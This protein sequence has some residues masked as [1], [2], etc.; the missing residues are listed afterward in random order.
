[1]LVQKKLTNNINIY[2]SNTNQN[3]ITTSLTTKEIVNVQQTRRLSVPSK[4][5][6]EKTN[7]NQENAKQTLKNDNYELIGQDKLA[8]FSHKAKSTHKDAFVKSSS[9]STAPSKQDSS[10]VWSTLAVSCL[11]DILKL[12]KTNNLFENIKISSSNIQYN[13]T[14]VNKHGVVTNTNKS[15]DLPAWV[16]QAMTSLVHWSD[17]KKDQQ[18]KLN[19]H[20][21]FKDV[22]NEVTNYYN[23]HNEP[24]LTQ[25]FS[26]LLLKIMRI[27]LSNTKQ[28]EIDEFMRNLKAHLN[29][30]A[31]LKQ[32]NNDI[33]MIVDYVDDDEAE[34][35]DGIV[36]NGDD[37]EDDDYGDDD[38]FCEQ[39][40]DHNCQQFNFASSSSQATH[41]QRSK[42]LNTETLAANNHE[43][44]CSQC[45]STYDFVNNWLNCNE[46]E[47]NDFVLNLNT[48]YR[49]LNHDNEPFSAEEEENMPNSINATAATASATITDSE[50]MTNNNKTVKNEQISASENERKLRRN[51]SFIAAI[52]D[53]TASS[54]NS[55]SGCNFKDVTSTHL[56][57]FKT[58]SLDHI[59]EAKNLVKNIAKMTN[60][61][62]VTMSTTTAP[63]NTINTT[64]T[65]SA[66]AADNANTHACI[67]QAAH[68]RTPSYNDNQKIIKNMLVNSIS[69]NN[70]ASQ[71]PTQ[72][73]KLSVGQLSSLISSVSLKDLQS[74]NDDESNNYGFDDETFKQIIKAFR[75]FTLFLPPLNKRKLHLLLRLL[76]KLK[77]SDHA[78]LLLI[79][80]YVDQNEINEAINGA[81]QS[82][83]E[84]IVR[85]YLA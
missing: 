14:H 47:F 72:L 9:T 57:M 58:L 31:C 11:Y 17:F 83:V 18:N 50:Y 6:K 16:M 51:N 38:V 4:I 10:E 15:D 8:T 26:T 42:S 27:F 24:L 73:S 3:L 40:D 21:S 46:I 60:N 77:Y 79:D 1:M 62:A 59:N 54:S 34:D 66:S 43:I 44:C 32:Q 5:L 76:Y 55:S 25:E 41:M 65:A 81:N 48:N 23:D 80:E 13:C 74:S 67:T 85:I 22:F 75:I 35:D 69:L 61:R 53:T 52:T 70:I 45:L 30:N 19:H 28:F 29:A 12:D 33:D 63:L 37:D 78:K 36:A 56:S 2:N 82:S 39:Y 20:P 84:S 68:K 7:V 71:L 49:L 64:H